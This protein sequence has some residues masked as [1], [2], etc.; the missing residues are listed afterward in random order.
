MSEDG[1]ERLEQALGHRFRDRDLLRRALTH[2]SRTFEDGSPDNEQLEFLGDSILG[3]L[4]S[5]ALIERYPDA[6]EGELSRWKAHLVSAKRLHQVAQQIGA[7]AHLLLG[8]GEEVTGGRNKKNLLADAVEALI[9][10]LYRDAGLHAARDF[11]VGTVMGQVSLDSEATEAAIDYKGALKESAVTLGYGEPRYALIQ[12]LGPEHA[13][14]FVVEVRLPNGLSGRGQGSTK[15]V[16]GRNA[17]R[18]LLA[19]LATQNPD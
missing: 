8:R 6:G 13:K 2:T 19:Q 15:K 11:V 4:V 16:A 1:T 18:E 10:A 9:A 14:T 7:G 12:E 17:A 3:F 5:E